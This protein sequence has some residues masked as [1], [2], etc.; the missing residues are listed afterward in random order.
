[1]FCLLKLDLICL[2]IYINLLLVG[3]EIL[4]FVEEGDLIFEN[5]IVIK[6]G[7]IIGIIYGYI[8][9]DSLVIEMDGYIYKNCY[10]IENINNDDFFFCLGD[11]G[12]GVYVI[13]G[14]NLIFLLGIVFVLLR[15]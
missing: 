10:G 5:D 12:F 15:L 3:K 4:I 6:R 1:M 2:K 8:I 7:K 9:N 14:N 11:F 13:R